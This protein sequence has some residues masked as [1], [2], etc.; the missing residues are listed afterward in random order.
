MK[1]FYLLLRANVAKVTWAVLVS[2]VSGASSA[3]LYYMVSHIWQNELFGS[4]AWL[5]GFVGVLALMVVTGYWG[6]IIV[7]D[8]ALSTVRDLRM[9]L[10]AK[11]LSTPLRQLEQIG[12]HRQLAVLTEDVTTLSRVL[13][14]ITRFATDITMVL[15]GVGY[16]AY[17]SWQALAVVSVFLAIGVGIYQLMM[18]RAM[19]HMRSSRDEF[20][21]VFDNFRALHEGAKQLKLNRKRRKLFLFTDLHNSLDAFRKFAFAGRRLLI[22]S[23]VLT[24]FLFFALIGAMIFAIPALMGELGGAVMAGYVGVAL[25]LFR[26]V[27]SLMLLVPDFGMAAVALKKIDDLGLTLDNLEMEKG[28]DQLDMNTSTPRAAKWEKLE[29]KGVAYTYSKA[30]D[31]HAFKM[32]PIDLT[33]RPGELIFV[34]GGNGS[35]KTTFAKVLCSLYPHDE[36]Q[37]LLDGELVTDEG[38]EDYRQLFSVVFFDFHLFGKLISDADGNID[39]LALKHLRDLELDHK[40]KVSDGV[41]S[42]QELSQGQRKRLA[43]LTAYLEDRPIYLFDEWAA[44]QD[45]QFKKIFYSKILPEL[46]ASGKTIIAIT[47]DDRYMHLADRCLKLEDGKLLEE[48]ELEPTREAGH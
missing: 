10:S 47:H 33:I 48:R 40:V 8:L 28:A 27:N 22:G 44:D 42:T 3:G 31:D 45:P 25:I 34:E 9:E 32:G 41:L 37:L 16:L 6:Q 11:I 29:L 38:R 13:P 35:G 36:G 15:A 7:L 14:Y 17:L 30:G 2:I 46:K 19:A 23:E 18:G 5:A 4:M 1:L 24:R 12:S 39:E 20:D 26:P 43:L 21:N